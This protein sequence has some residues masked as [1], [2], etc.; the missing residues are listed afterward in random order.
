MHA[1][2]CSFAELPSQIVMSLPA[3]R[4]HPVLLCKC[5][6]NGQVTRWTARRHRMA[7][8]SPLIPQHESPPPPKRRHITHSQ[9]GQESFIVRP[10]KQK[11]SRTANSV[12]HSR[13][14][15]G[16]SFSDHPRFSTPQSHASSS[17]FNP[18]LPLLSSPVEPNTLESPGDTRTEAT[19]LSVDNQTTDQS[20]D[21]DSDDTLERDA[22]EAFDHETDDLWDEEGVASEGD[23]D[24]REGI[25]SDWDLLV[26]EFLVEAEEL[27]KLEHSSLYTP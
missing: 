1:F 20:D 17:G 8:A 11:Q 21:A 16:S 19:R 22:V 9:A 5:G 12:S 4:K 18:S 27:G 25:V 13:A 7:H 26:E 14:D 15:V 24:P 23:A 2:S 6:C 3:P 10:E